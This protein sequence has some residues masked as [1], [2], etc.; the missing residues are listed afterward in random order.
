MAIFNKPDFNTVWANTGVKLQPSSAK[1]SQ[2][3]IVEIPPYEQM[4][5]IQNRQDQMLAHINQYGIPLWDSNTEYRAN[6]SHVTSTTT[7]VVYKCLI[8]HTNR[9]PEVD[10][11]GTWEVAFERAGSAL[12]KAQN[13]A[14]VPNKAL[15][16]QN[17]GIQTTSDYDL[18]YLTKSGNLGDVLNKA[19]ARNNLDVYSKSEVYTKTETSLLFPAGE[20]KYFL[21]DVAPSGFVEVRGQALLKSQYPRLWEAVKNIV[22]STETHF[23]LPDMRGE[24]LRA[25]DRGRGI[26]PGRQVGT[27]QLSQ[28]LA[29]SHSGTTD[30][31]GEH[32]HP[33]GSTNRVEYDSGG[34]QRGS[35]TNTNTY[36]GLGG[37]HE[38]TLI[39][40]NS[41]GSEARPRNIALLCC[42]STGQ[43]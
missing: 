7:G 10:S 38:H 41:G 30:L 13:L 37:D 26:D 35:G 14:D 16:R 34:S 31:S 33:I 32:R 9:N 8:T 40:G 2:G 21:T 20:V 3:W 18:R 25:A 42:I 11:T 1:V 12:L 5:W 43:V 19:T 22:S 39:I 24:F 36:S 23:T 17:L 27:A 28:N 15:A 6:F 4:N 29:H